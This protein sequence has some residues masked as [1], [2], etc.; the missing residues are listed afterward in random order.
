MVPRGGQWTGSEPRTAF[1]V[2]ASL[3]RAVS[4]FVTT[5]WRRAIPGRDKKVSELPM[6]VGMP[7]T[8]QAIFGE[9]R[10]GVGLAAAGAV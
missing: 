8:E 2:D 7:P 5:C 3:L 10:W 9:I 4:G 1:S 6:S